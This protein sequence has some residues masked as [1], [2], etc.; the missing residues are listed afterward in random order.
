MTAPAT[1]LL[2]HNLPHVIM[3]WRNLLAPHCGRYYV[4]GEGA[5]KEQMLYA[6]A[7]LQPAIVLMDAAI[8]GKRLAATVR[9]LRASVAHVKLLICWQ[10]CHS[11]LVQPNPALAMGYLAEDVP[12]VEILQALGQMVRG[13]NY[14]C[15]QS[16]RLFSPPAEGP[17]LPPKHRQLLWCMRQRFTAIEMAEATDLAVNTVNGYVRDLYDLIGSRS[18]PALEY[19]MKKEGME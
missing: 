5:T 1:V 17:P 9:Q 12:T 7:T 2:V 15:R 18:M 10:Y 13:N 4:G 6:A 8:G 3:M 11:G 16:E 19:F 14:Y